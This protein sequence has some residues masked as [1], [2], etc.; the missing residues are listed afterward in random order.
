MADPSVQDLTVALGDK[1]SVTVKE[2]VELDLDVDERDNQPTVA[3]KWCL[4]G[5][6]L[7]KRRYN[8]EALENALAGVWRPVEGMHMRILCENLF[9]FYFFHPVDMQQVM[10]EGPWRFV[11][12]TMVLKEAQG[13]RQ[14]TKEDLFE[15][16]FWVQIPGLRSER[17][18]A[19]TRR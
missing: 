14:V 10:A 16:S 5:T 8:L 15:V 6:L 12:H 17:L 3:A 2:D 4:V 18:T 19:A 13:G 9:A 11:N 7:I 1:L